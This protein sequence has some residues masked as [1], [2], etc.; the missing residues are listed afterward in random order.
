MDETLA[1]LAGLS[2]RHRAAL[3]LKFYADLP[4]AEIAEALGCRPGTVKSLLHRGLAALK[5]KI[6]R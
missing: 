2:A 4:E 3:V 6:E 5:E 1:A